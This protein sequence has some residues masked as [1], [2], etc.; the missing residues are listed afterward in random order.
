LTNHDFSLSLLTPRI[1]DIFPGYFLP[2][3]L[4]TTNYFAQ[5][6]KNIVQYGKTGITMR[7]GRK[8]PWDKPWVAYAAIGGVIIVII[9]ALF[10]FFG[11]G[12]TAG[13]PTGPVTGSS[14]TAGSSTT[15]GKAP[16][17]NYGTT[18]VVRPTA[19]PV[20]IPNQGI[21]VKVSYIGG[22]SGTYGIPGSLVKAQDS[23]VRVYPI[24]STTGTITA[25]FQKDDGSKHQLTVE[26]LKDG[27]VVKSGT[28][29]S[30]NGKVSISYQV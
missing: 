8:D 19:T 22:F 16:T 25:S 21:A 4:P 10:Y 29:S 3:I 17:M 30:P 24:D 1:Q 5:F 26:I 11:G 23:G 12:G 13:A 14:G 7:H 28:A 9:I 20:A 2:A 27:N 18:P 6:S 15:V